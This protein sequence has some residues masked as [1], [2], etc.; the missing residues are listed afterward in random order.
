MYV[1]KDAYTTIQ[2][3]KKSSENFLTWVCPLLKQSIIAAD[4]VLFYESDIIEDI[5]FQLNGLSGYVIPFDT[6]VVYIQIEN[7]DKF[8]D[9]DFIASGKSSGL[10]IKE[11]VESMES[12]KL[13]LVRYFTVICLKETNLMS[14]DVLNLHR[15]SK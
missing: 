2:F 3:L 9:I 6:N 5:Y 15:M 1:Y 14:I 8:G 12:S 11:I 7:G 10:E 13:V 4:Q